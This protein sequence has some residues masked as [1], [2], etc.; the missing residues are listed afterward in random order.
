MTDCFLITRFNLPLYKTD[1]ERQPVLTEQWLSDRFR[2]FETYC[3]PS[4][5]QQTYK[6]FVWIVLMSDDTPQMYR[7][8][9]SE[10]RAQCR[11]LS[12]LYIKNNDIERYHDIVKDKIRERKS[13]SSLL[14]TLRIDNDDAIRC[15][16]IERAVTL[17]RQQTE[18]KRGYSYVY[19][20]QY[21]AKANLAMRVP[22]PN[23]HF[24]FEINTQYKA[25]DFDYILEYNH[26]N[27]ADMPFPFTAMMDKEVMW[28]EVIHQR[29]VDND[30][31]GTW[32]QRPV[33]DNKLLK[34]AF[35]WSRSLSA[36]NTWLKIPGYL[37]P[38]ALHHGMNRLREK[39]RK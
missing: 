31:K 5:Q 8:R 21:H 9:M 17:A 35:G 14:V 39:M 29:N 19:G 36:L 37:M 11:Q 3:L 15:D 34:D 16:Y 30:V 27:T 12:P 22:Y 32:R 4:I 2:L 24:I 25:D 28:A 38:A 20:I 6:D 1:K 33:T 23:N 10:L 18:P 7:Q 26:A 13:Q